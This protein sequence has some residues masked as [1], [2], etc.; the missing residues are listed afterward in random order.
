MMIVHADRLCDE[1][2]AVL[3]VV[4]ASLTR[5]KTVLTDTANNTEQELRQ[6]LTMV[7]TAIEQ[8]RAIVDAAHADFKNW[9][10]EGQ[11][12]TTERIAE[13]KAKRQTSK[14]HARADRFELS[15]AAAVEMGAAAMREA[16]REVL[17]ALLMRK[18]AIAIQVQ[19]DKRP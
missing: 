13:W 11:S 2:H 5:L 6:S 7:E 4:E 15:A 3:S 9:F 12:E 17:R 14:L 19:Q 16:E 8:N 18:E 10:D 1:L